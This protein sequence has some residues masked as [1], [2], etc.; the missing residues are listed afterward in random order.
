MKALF[1]IL[2]LA[3]LTFSSCM[4]GEEVDLII[5]NARIHTMVEGD[6]KVH[7]AI[8]IKNGKIVEIGPERQILNKYSA[9]EYIDAGKK[10]VYP[11][12]VDAH[13][14][15]MNYARSR[16]SVDLIGCKSFDEMILRI[17]KYQSRYKRPF[18]IGRGWD[19]S[20]WGDEMPTNEKLNELF[21]DIP[22]CLFR[23]DGHALLANDFLIDQADIF[24]AYQA[25]FELHNG[26]HYESA[27]GAVELKD[28][29]EN[30]GPQ[31]STRLI[32]APAKPTGVFVDNAMNP[33][34]E[35]LPDFPEKE[36]SASLIEVQNELLMYGVTGVHEAG[37]NDKD[38]KLFRKM[39]DQ[40]KLKLNIYAML[41]TTPGNVKF[42]KDKGIWRNK[43]LYVRSFKVYGDG[44]LGSRGAFLKY[45]YADRHDHSGYLTTSPQRMKE[46]FDLCQLTG[47]QMNTHAI[48]DSTNKIMLDIYKDMFEYNPNHRWRIEHAQIVDPADFNLFA[49]TGVIPSVQP[50]HATS[51]QRWAE[52]RL[53]EDRMEG[54]YAFKS[55]MK[56]S[57]LLA[58]G[59]DF[60]V[61]YTDPFKTIHSAVERKNGENFPSEGF[62]AEEAITLEECILGMTRWAAYASFQEDRIGTL[63]EGKD[64]TISMFQKPVV[65]QSTFVA[66]FAELVLIKGKKVYSA[67]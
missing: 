41:L 5:H 22:V 34:M 30:Y 31:P 52:S 54:A 35:V 21:P 25:D 43:N 9:K 4:K 46:I 28:L 20:L 19:Q 11:G 6:D 42:A 63:E 59:T 53:G 48:G 51:D 26:G 2:V 24:K 66:N 1:P 12:W 61:E 67:E 39:V 7:E 44:A 56:Q 10:D 15:M 36:L 50:T 23:I 13:G 3:L 57:G 27:E 55:L 32:P 65:S 8:A 29:T 60:P 40:R 37:L 64:A 58:I 16:I 14:H 38:F 18:I 33:I 17:E 62:R 49:A 45:P 47:Y